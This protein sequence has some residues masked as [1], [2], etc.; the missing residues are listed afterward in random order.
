M[1]KP[2]RGTIARSASSGDFIGNR[3]NSPAKSLPAR[4]RPAGGGWWLLVRSCPLDGPGKIR[5]K[6]DASTT[7]GR[8]E[9]T[10]MVYLSGPCHERGPAREGAANVRRA[11]GRSGDG[12]WG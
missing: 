3:R 8:R 10:V 7:I 5:E 2:G 11:I 9:V 4:P 12:G 1:R 6:R